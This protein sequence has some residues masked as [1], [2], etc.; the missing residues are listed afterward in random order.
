M[1]IGCKRNSEK[2]TTIAEVLMASALLVT[3]GAGILGSFRYG[4]FAMQLARE[5]QR[6]TQI[7]LE[8]VE[9]I[10]LYSWD[11]VNSNGFVPSTF[12]DVYDPQ[13]PAGN[14]GVT[15]NGSVLITNFPSGVSYSP[16]LRQFTVSLQWTNSQGLGRSRTLTTWV[17]KDGLQ[18]YVY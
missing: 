13:A 17:A 6:A 5:N 12:T 18:N 1:K 7:V 8:K 2:G 9:T 16:N 15:Y 14:R 4:F 10:R 11:Q 3:V